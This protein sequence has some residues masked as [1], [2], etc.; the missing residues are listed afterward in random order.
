MMIAIGA[1]VVAAILLVATLVMRA[2]RQESEKQT[3]KL[4]EGFG[5]EYSRA[6]GEQ[7]RSDAEGDLLKRQKRA[8]L[9]QVRGALSD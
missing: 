6:V 7:G 9:F 8:D 5:P 4:R 3:T 2:K 1:A